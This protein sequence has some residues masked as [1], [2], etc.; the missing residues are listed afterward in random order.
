[1]NNQ[2]SIEIHPDWFRDIPEM[3]FLILGS[4]PPHPT[5]R[6]YPF[7]YPNARNRFWP[8]LADLAGIKLQWTKTDKPKAVE[9]RF[10]IMLKLKAGVQNLGYEIEREGMS[11][12]DTRIS[13]KKFHDILSIINTHPE[14]ERILLP[15]YSAISSTARSFIRY[16]NENKIA[17]STDVVFKPGNNFNFQMGERRINCVILNSTST[18]CRVGYS[19]LLEQFRGSLQ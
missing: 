4:F 3:R 13:I 8:V 7:F 12:L 17:V 15:G 19:S 10:E 9:E 14:L 2:K 16:L 1:M 6:L 18:A 5:K 11:A